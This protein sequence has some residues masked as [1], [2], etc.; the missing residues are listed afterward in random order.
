MRYVGQ[1]ERS[2]RTRYKE[3]YRDYKNNN[4][5]SKYAQYL[6]ED[7]HSISSINDTMGILYT[8]RKGKLLD[9]WEKFYI[10]KEILWVPK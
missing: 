9:T 6:L 2:C 1:T 10:Y 4:K 3:H 8:V 7:G 5:T